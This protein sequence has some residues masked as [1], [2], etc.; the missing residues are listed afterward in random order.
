MTYFAEAWPVAR[1][2]HRCTLCARTI[3]PAEKYRRGVCLD[4]SVYTFKECGHCCAVMALTDPTGGDYEYSSDVLAEWE[5]YGVTELRWKA[6]WKR[7]WQRRD[8]ALYPLPTLP[9]AAA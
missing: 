7:K 6:Q 4:G 3:R 2:E 1:K 9:E 8:G 5:P